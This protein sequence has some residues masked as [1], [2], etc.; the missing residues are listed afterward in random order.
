MLGVTDRQIEMFE[1]ASESKQRVCTVF[2]AVRDIE[3]IGKRPEMTSLE[4][5]TFQADFPTAFKK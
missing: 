3:V 5:L 2:E 1:L 4:Q